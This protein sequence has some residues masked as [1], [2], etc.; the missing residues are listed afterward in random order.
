MPSPVNIVVENVLE[1]D[2][3][4]GEEGMTRKVESCLGVG[5]A[6][7][8]TFAELQDVWGIMYIGEL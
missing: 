5:K 4:A 8:P 7:M 1:C 6:P 3:V 2:R